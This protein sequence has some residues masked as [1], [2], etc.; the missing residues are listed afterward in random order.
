MGAFLSRPVTE[1][2]SE[3][4]SGSGLQ[5]GASSMQGWRLH[6][7]DAH[8]A[9]L[10]LQQGRTNDDKG[11]AAVSEGSMKANRAALFG[12]FDGH[13]GREIALFC[14][15]H[16]ARELRS[17]AAFQSGDFEQALRDVFH[18]MDEMIRDEQNH[19][20]I[21]SLMNDVNEIR[22]VAPR[23][24]E[25]R[26]AI[27]N[28][29][30]TGGAE[31]ADLDR[32]DAAADSGAAAVSA[33][34][35]SS[36]LEGAM[37]EREAGDVI[38]LPAPPQEPLQMPDAATQGDSGSQES[39][40]HALDLLQQYVERQGMDHEQA[41]SKR[42]PE[43]VLGDGPDGC[44]RSA[45]Q[46]QQLTHESDEAR[47][48]A[49]SDRLNHICRLQEYPII[50][51]STSVVALLIDN[52]LYVANAGD[53]KAV[54]SRGGCAVPLS[55]EHKPGLPE[56][57]A[58]IEKAGGFVNHVG[59]VNNN[60]N[61]SRAIGDL[62]YKQNKNVPREAQMITAEP[63][64]MR[65]ELGDTDEFMVMGCDGIWDVLTEQQAVDF[66]RARVLS[67]S[68]TLSQICEDIFDACIA[69]DPRRTS[70]LGGDN[71]T[72]IIVQFKPAAGGS[73]P[74]LQTASSKI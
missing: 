22:Q 8:I 20:E 72:A 44:S 63:D 57:T 35:R 11:T 59:R 16:F 18:R 67:G 61:L 1:K 54:L 29:A 23:P 6:M 24:S 33:D 74:P 71:M 50:A 15:R 26:A 41:V 69:D 68:R 2:S 65:V 32:V 42:G 13:G 3:E 12:V 27:E 28:R 4:A 55:F 38:Y 9:H 53:S 51:G 10:N 64:I 31:S 48:Q 14:K 19:P 21:R 56:E 58:R 17:S 5:Y 52:S 25:K 39:L 73:P 45:E 60:L 49:E 36:S 46:D 34:P 7:E 62:K 66:V 47:A 40:Q 30:D 43:Q 37:V 70:G